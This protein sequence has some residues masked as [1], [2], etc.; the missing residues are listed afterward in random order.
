[1]NPPRPLL[2]LL[3]GCACAKAPV[4]PPT[5][6]TPPPPT[7]PAAQPEPPAPAEPAPPTCRVEAAPAAA[8]PPPAAACV[9]VPAA[10]Q[11][12]LSAELRR[13]FRP[14]APGGK[15]AASYECDPLA[16]PVELVY[17][18]GSGHG[19]L[20][21]LTRLRWR[22][23]TIEALRLRGN[24]ELT[25]ERASFGRA[26]LDAALPEL[27]ALALA[28]LE[29]QRP[30]E[31][32]GMSAYGSSHDWFALVRLVDD[33]G[34]ALERGFAGYD[35]SDN[36]LRS[37][38]VA[39]LD[40]RVESALEKVTWQPAAIDDD[41]RAFFV[42][43]FLAG[44]EEHAE[45]WVREHLVALAGAAGTPALVP[46]L[47]TRAQDNN[48]DASAERTREHALAALAQLAGFDARKDE[49]GAPVPPADAAAAYARACAQG[50]APAK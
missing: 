1:M 10:L 13:A 2:A 27:R 50:G 33:A 42:A 20:V 17:E 32:R 15:L 11:K 5:A 34:R 22:D 19:H 30:P 48:A 3:L 9:P 6:E 35:N 18:T 29:E 4:T 16:A 24:P 41:A 14:T 37:I 8:A 31:P 45:W 26:A 21:S 7:A 38:P 39:A 23:R 40:K 44:N 46:A 28:R 47:I 49:R 36:Q 12:R 43:R 25:V